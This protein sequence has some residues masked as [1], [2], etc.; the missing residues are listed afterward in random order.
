MKQLLI[1]SIL[2][3]SNIFVTYSMG[4]KPAKEVNPQDTLKVYYLDEVVVRSSVKE[5]NNLKN[6]PTAVSVVSP[7][8]LKDNQI[9]SLPALSSF[10]PNFFIPQYGSKV[11]TPI[12][13]RG[14]GARLGAQTV[15][16]YVDNVPSFNPSAFDFEF[17][18]IQRIEVLRGAQGT[19]YGRNAI[20]G[21][22]NMYTLSPLTYQGTRL[23]LGG[24]NYGQFSVNGSN[25][26]QLSKN[27]GVSVNA[28]YKKEDGYF[29][30]SY[31]N[32]KVDD[33][34]NAGGK[35]KL[36]WQVNP[37]FKALFFSH[38][39]YLSGGAFPY[40]HVD[41]IS[42]RFNEPSSYDRRLFTN[43]LSLSWN[44]NGYTIHSTT[45]FQYLKDDMKM[46]QDY[47]EKSVF[48]I[49]QK[50]EQHSVSQEF[51]LKSNTAKKY[52]WVWGAF[53]FYDRRVVDTPVA[54]KEDGMVAMQGHLDAAMQRMGAPL[55]IVYAN[56]RID[57]PG[58]YTK[59][60]RGLALFHQ[61]TLSDLF[62]V[63]GLSATAG[64]RLDY[65]HTG[66]DF[67]T[68]SNGGDVNLVFNIPNRPMPPMFVEGDT[69]LEGSYSKD[70]WKVLPKV[71]L[72]YAF[73][74]TSTIY[75][76]ASKGYKT[77]GYNEQAFSKILQSALSASIM[78][79]AMSGMPPGMFP[80]G[81]PGTG[82]S[83]A[84]TTSL[85]EQLS[86]D[87]ETSWTYEMGGRYELLNNKMSI[88]Y[89]L[90]YSRV[91]NIQIIQLEDQ[92]TSGRTVKNAGTSESKGFELSMKYSPIRNLSLYGDYGFADARFVDYEAAE[93]VDYS[94][95]YIPFAP[96]H[97]LSLGAGYV[98]QFGYGSFIERLNANVQYSG[99][100][101]I[102]WTESNKTTPEANAEGVE[103]YQPFYGLVNGKIAAEKG[104]FSLELWVKNLFNTDYNSF[105]FEASDMTT[106]KVNQFVQRGYPT[107][108]G[109]TLR[110]TFNR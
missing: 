56:D 91:N 36:E 21:I 29:L 84:E 92:G 37:N 66:I 48:S 35:V 5:T 89:A 105:L 65:E 9:E 85:E 31:L 90:F 53:G 45:G 3:F 23:T 25:Y 79:N 17:Q 47:T 33:S 20:G 108:M 39:D 24:G 11:S 7:R 32:E 93:G 106:G 74:P 27:F 14:I 59:P 97:T 13:I 103:L 28:Y 88:N 110:Y 34:E 72:K 1:A 94:G 16:L 86:Y 22:V 70:F 42:S 4:N 69:L 104:E 41:S 102:Y 100:G 64:L 6:L 107:R 51:T 15:S 50:Q 68:E 61:S 2:L 82:N 63:E 12:Y 62:G 30:N 19:L 109:V 49:N 43:G 101:R 96:Q 57:L 52:S 83:G 18:D 71:A 80:G 40:M 55:R 98:H 60:S 8:Q 76:S 87:P 67:S 46:D 78:K 26:S 73:S 10:I 77:G 99:V 38:F 81:A 58:I 44:K 95:N 54:I 75:V